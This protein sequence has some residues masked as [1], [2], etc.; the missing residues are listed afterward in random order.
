[1]ERY[2]ITVYNSYGDIVYTVIQYTEAEMLQEI[3]DGL[4]DGFSVHV[5]KQIQ[6]NKGGQN[7]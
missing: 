1:M 6:V 4:N 3:R 5:V 2:V 7:D